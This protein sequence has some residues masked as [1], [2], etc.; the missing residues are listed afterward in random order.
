MTWLL[1]SGCQDWEREGGEREVAIMMPTA[2]IILHLTV[3]AIDSLRKTTKAVKIW[4]RERE[5][6]HAHPT[7]QPGVLFFFCCYHFDPVKLTWFEAYQPVFDCCACQL[8]LF[9]FFPPTW[10]AVVRLI[11]VSYVWQRKKKLKFLRSIK[12]VVMF[13]MRQDMRR[14]ERGYVW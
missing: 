13:G 12:Q 4:K 3:A 5:I 8:L 6:T 7:R 9:L 14:W 11:N 2:L 10:M 1:V